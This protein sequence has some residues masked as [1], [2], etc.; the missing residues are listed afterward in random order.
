MPDILTVLTLP[1]IKI[2]LIGQAIPIT[3]K[4]G[5]K[6]H[7]ISL[8]GISSPFNSLVNICPIKQKSAGLWRA[9]L[10]HNH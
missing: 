2:I 7:L 5:K 4:L 10:L 9:C 3:L 8:I 1:R 6:S